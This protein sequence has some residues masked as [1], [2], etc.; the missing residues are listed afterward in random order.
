MNNQNIDELLINI[1]CYLDY[2]LNNKY[3]IILRLINDY[4]NPIYN[5]SKIKSLQ[6]LTIDFI[7]KNAD[8]RNINNL[9]ILEVNNLANYIIILKLKYIIKSIELQEF[10]YEK[11]IKKIDNLSKN[12][13]D[14]NYFIN[15]RLNL[16][17]F[18]IDIENEIKYFP[19]QLLSNI[20]LQK[21]KTLY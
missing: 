16:T 5:Q 3:E 2:D 13:S 4:L 15:K 19:N 17:L 6:F 11:F 9:N 18:N 1:F 21:I 20:L 10:R 7:A 8:I 12:K 14:Y